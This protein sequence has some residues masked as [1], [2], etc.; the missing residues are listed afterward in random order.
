[1]LTFQSEREQ[2]IIRVDCTHSCDFLGSALAVACARDSKDLIAK[3]ELDLVDHVRAR[4]ESPEGDEKAEKNGSSDESVIFFMVT[5]LCVLRKNYRRKK[6]SVWKEEKEGK[7]ERNRKKHIM[8]FDKKKRLIK[9]RVERLSGSYCVH[10]GA[11]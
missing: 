1:M 11:Q 7:Q 10:N 5:H 4:Y 6:A 2:L 3:T 9:I 8:Q